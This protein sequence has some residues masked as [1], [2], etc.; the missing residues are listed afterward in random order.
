MNITDSS[1][2]ELLLLSFLLIGC[3]FVSV[4]SLN[5]SVE[6]V[7]YGGG[8]PYIDFLTGRL[9]ATTG[10]PHFVCHIIPPKI[11]YFN[12]KIKIVTYL[13]Y[14]IHLTESEFSGII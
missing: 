5:K 7:E 9:Q 3:V 8:I 12:N 4:I 10:Y 13:K 14:G 11:V 6:I 2:D 1:I